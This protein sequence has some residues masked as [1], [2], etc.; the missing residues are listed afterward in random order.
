LEYFSHL[1]NDELPNR[2]EAKRSLRQ[3]LKDVDKIW[4][5]INKNQVA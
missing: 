5:V 2:Q 3:N 1:T 4:V